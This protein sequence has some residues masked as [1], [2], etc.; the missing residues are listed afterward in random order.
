MSAV[1][2]ALGDSVTRSLLPIVAV[3][4]LGAGTAVVGILN[5]LGLVAFIFLSLPIGV[6]GDRA[7]SPLTLMACSTLVRAVLAAAGLTAWVLGVLQGEAGLMLL[8]AIAVMIGIADVAFSAGQGLLIPRI[9]SQEEIRPLFGVIQTCAQ[10][11]AA[12]GPLLLALMLAVVAAP[13]VWVMPLLMYAGSLAAQAP[14]RETAVQVP[15]GGTSERRPL[16]SGAR[17]GFEVLFGSQM[18]RSVSIANSLANATAMAGNTLLPILVMSHFGYSGALFS[19]LGA[20]AALAGAGA[21]WCGSFLAGRFG[22]KRVRLVV[23]IAQLL[24]VVAMGLVAA[25]PSWVPGEPIFWLMLQSIL[26]GS[27]AAITMVA[28]ADLPA[29]IAP[30][31]V[32]GAVMGAQ[33]LLVV[34]A[35]PVAALMVGVLGALGLFFGV[36]AWVVLALGFCI[37]TTVISGDFPEYDSAASK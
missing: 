12:S 16:W 15:T 4:V 9:A 31:G 2:E 10:I 35:M 3:T 18:L 28:G 33:R 6:L 17:A 30:S 27:G 13:W 22:L 29:R 20:V 36:T 19:L 32:L 26:A 37:A 21:A 25:A 1:F 24:S 23:A 34:G 5:S 11:G 14:I 8:L 7:R